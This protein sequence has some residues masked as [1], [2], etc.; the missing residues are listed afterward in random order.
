MTSFSFKLVLLINDSLKIIKIKNHE[1]IINKINYDI[2]N[3]L[4]PENE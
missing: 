2:Q 4:K 3:K 1:Q